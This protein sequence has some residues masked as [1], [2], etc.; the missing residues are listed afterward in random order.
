VSTTSLPA[1]SPSFLAQI[2]EGAAGAWAGF[3]SSRLLEV[4]PEL[5]ER[6]GA[7]AF[8]Q[9]KDHF[10][11]RLLE[12]ASAL[13]LEQPSLFVTEVR[14]ARRAFMARKLSVADLERSL[15]VLRGVLE[16]ELPSD[17]APILEH[18]FEPA[19]ATLIEKDRE[20]PA[21][22]DAS[23]AGRFALRYLEAVLDGDRRAALAVAQEA[24]DEGMTLGEL[25]ET[26]LTPAQQEIG[27]LWHH[28]EL[29]ISEEHFA[30]RTTQ[31]VMDVL[32]HAAEA[33]PPNGKTVL[34]AAVEGNAHDMA[35]RAL[36]DLFELRGW[37]AI[38]LG[39][40]VPRDELVLAPQ[41][42]EVDL[43]VLSATLG[44]QL[45][46]LGEVIRG[47][48]QTDLDR[49]VRVLIG[50]RA[51]LELPDLWQQLGADGYAETMGA[52]VEEAERLLGL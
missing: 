17:A 13:A 41:I 25:Y 31:R 43:V 50:G 20:P 48:R 14:W 2:I 52:A 24:V 39:S 6:F 28:G 32:S 12:L 44:V 29:S 23:A 42:F 8:E 11:Q 21:I 35:V 19:L 51:L 27:R 5:E 34:C 45:P 40:D 9:W 33:Q 38:P 47:L 3:A 1:S 18:Y 7:G 49:P 30:T 46:I 10:R 15:E 22:D 26:V 36:A 4:E 16:S 37:R